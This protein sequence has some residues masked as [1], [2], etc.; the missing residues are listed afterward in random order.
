MPKN[1]SMNSP[2]KKKMLYKSYI[3][4]ISARSYEPE[5]VDA[6]GQ[7][8]A[9][10][11]GY[12]IMGDGIRASR[13]FSQDKENGF[14]GLTDVSNEAILN[15]L[16][17]GEVLLI[18]DG[19][20]FPR[21]LS[22]MQLDGTEYLQCM[23][24]EE[25]FSYHASRDQYF[26]D[27]TEII[28]PDQ[29]DFLTW[30]C[31]LFASLILGR[32]G[33][34]M[35]EWMQYRDLYMKQEG[36]DTFMH[37]EAVT[38]RQTEADRLL[39]EQVRMIQQQQEQ[40]QMQEQQPQP[41]QEQQPR[42]QQEQQPQP[43]EVSAPAEQNEIV[44]V[45][46]NIQQKEEVPQQQDEK[47]A[48]GEE[49]K[50]EEEQPVAENEA[51]ESVEKKEEEPA[52][53][54]KKDEPVVEEKQDEAPAAEVKKE[55][56]V[57]EDKK[58]VPVVED[59]KDEP[60][61][62]QKDDDKLPVYNPVIAYSKDPTVLRK[63]LT[64]AQ[65]YQSRLAAAEQMIREKQERERQKEELLRKKQEEK[66]KLDEQKEKQKW[67][68][69]IKKSEEMDPNLKGELE[70]IE[71]RK[72][73]FSERVRAEKEQKKKDEKVAQAVRIRERR[74]ARNPLKTSEDYAREQRRLDQLLAAEKQAREE[75]RAFEKRLAELQQKR[76][77]LMTPER[78]KARSLRLE[79][80]NRMMVERDM[81]LAYLAKVCFENRE[82]EF[83]ANVPK[84]FEDLKADQD[85]RDDAYRA[86]IDELSKKLDKASGKE[87]K[88]ISKQHDAVWDEYRS[89]E[90]LYEK[91]RKN[92]GKT[93][94]KERA[95]L[96]DQFV[97]Y[98]K[99]FD[100]KGADNEAALLKVIPED[101]RKRVEEKRAIDLTGVVDEI[102][103]LGNEEKEYY[104]LG[105]LEE[106]MKTEE[107]ARIEKELADSIWF[108][109]QHE[110]RMKETYGDKF[111]EVM[112]KEVVQNKKDLEDAAKRGKEIAER[113]R[114]KEEQE[115][116]QFKFLKQREREV[117]RA[118]EE[119][120]WDNHAMDE[121]NEMNEQ[122]EMSEKNE[123]KEK[124]VNKGKGG[125]V[126]GV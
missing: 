39:Q 102:E 30:I 27:K 32:H 91:E 34:A 80:L 76:K 14:V 77:E 111:R 44:E 123:K 15:R 57:A 104:E 88:I 96:K 125:P 16:R 49:E 19:N 63:Q 110:E 113:N 121:Q 106:R 85:R 65:D 33:K 101:V 86:R 51:N 21:S 81:P 9:L 66:R 26:E 42:P 118:N 75:H 24:P 122:N 108:A 47:Q 68:D 55:D 126:R 20:G 23:S 114:I 70:R 119:D 90:D 120:Y 78:V 45:N 107:K 35:E 29:P 2:A 46:E 37:S 31:D 89:T 53:E 117:L 8:D 59:K 25:A 28:P 12:G 67:A 94:E 50:K 11:T 48:E 83:E 56:P 84:R 61:P 97:K 69:A 1:E 41:Q 92:L 40:E 18:S 112:M 60:A 72:K 93:I 54:D 82:N 99:V 79:Q 22:A 74:E 17:S 124:E 105:K 116:R 62:Q 10:L 115:E 38:A 13:I 7:L 52:I 98:Q 109:R 3:N 64:M 58:E 73:E 95:T 71:Q 4:S 36:I 103:S 5:Q 87:E 6:G 100:K 43:Q